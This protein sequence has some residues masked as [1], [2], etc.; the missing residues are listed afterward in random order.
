MYGNT[1]SKDT[2]SNYIPFGRKEEGP[3]VNFP[4]MIISL[5][6]HISK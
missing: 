4:I 6:D 2:Y 5:Y 3:N 1:A